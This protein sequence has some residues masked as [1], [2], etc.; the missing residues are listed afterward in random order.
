MRNRVPVQG[1][2]HAAASNSQTRGVLVFALSVQECADLGQRVSNPVQADRENI[3]IPPM[4]VIAHVHT[5][6][7][8]GASARH[9]A[10]A[11]RLQET[12]QTLKPLVVAGKGLCT[13]IGCSG[14]VINK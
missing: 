9:H 1:E 4:V 6:R 14:V 11:M 10:R 3:Q 13:V 12:S 2:V 5:Q 8:I 7:Y